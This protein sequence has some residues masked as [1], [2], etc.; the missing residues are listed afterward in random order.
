MGGILPFIPAAL[1]VASQLGVFGKGAK[2]GKKVEYEAQAPEYQQ[3]FAEEFFK[4]LQGQVGQ[5]ATPFG[6]QVAAPFQNPFTQG[7]F[8]AMKASPYG[9]MMGGM[10]M[11]G[12]PFVPPQAP[13]QPQTPQGQLPPG[14]PPRMTPGQRGQAESQVMPFER[15]FGRYSPGDR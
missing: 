6:G 12:M 10:P 15:R 4:Y 2:E 11:G 7:A 14:M 9:S 1:G 8:G 13:Q 3:Q 5:G